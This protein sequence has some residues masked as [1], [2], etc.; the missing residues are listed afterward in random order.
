ML[1]IHSFEQLPDTLKNAV[2]A[3][4]NF[5]GVHRG[6]MA[7]MGEAGRVARANQLPWLVMTFEPHPRELF[8][9]GGP[10]YRL[11]PFPTKARIIEGLGVDGLIVPTFDRAFSQLSAKNFIDQVLVKGLA[12]G[13]VVSGYD[14]AFGNDRQGN[15][16]LLLSVGR[17]A[18]FDFTAVS[19]VRE[20]TGEVY[21]STRAREA[22][23]SG[24]M[25]TA[26]SILTR[27]YEITGEVISGDQR[28]RT[29][30]APTANIAIGEHIRPAYGVYA[31]LA[32][33]DNGKDQ[34]ANWIH[35][36]AN[37]GLRPTV[38][39]EHELLEAHLF[40][41]AEDIYGK[42]LRIKLIDH[43]RNE[44]KFDGLEALKLQIKEDI[45]KAKELLANI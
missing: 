33:I 2:V 22:V 19:A 30:G 37:I 39:G 32:A 13:H 5:D 4:G 42:S 31:I 10:A 23:K 38:D 9:P 45:E 16:E 20:A 34:A 28:G 8:K 29:I 14:F 1:I 11:T 43:I 41:F 44:R 17:D 3:V 12:A 26:A 18:G 15:C 25:R 36:V 24:D 21:S 40:N 35:G 7:V 6:H 27:P